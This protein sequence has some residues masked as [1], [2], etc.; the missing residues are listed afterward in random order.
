MFESSVNS[1]SIQT[2]HSFS[3]LLIMFESSVNSD[4]IQTKKRC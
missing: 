2:F 4:S 1:D 3:L